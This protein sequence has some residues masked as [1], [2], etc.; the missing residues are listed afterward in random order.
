MQLIRRH[1][2]WVSVTRLWERE[3]DRVSQLSPGKLHKLGLVGRYN[4]RSYAGS[5]RQTFLKRVS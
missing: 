4:H 3:I 2:D 1:V 5:L